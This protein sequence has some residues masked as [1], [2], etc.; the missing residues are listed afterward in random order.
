MKRVKHI[1]P[2]S[3]SR[4]SVRLNPSLNLLWII[5]IPILVF[6][7]YRSVLNFDLVNWDDKRYLKETPVIRGIT[8]DNIESMFTTKVLRS[9]NPLVLLS[10]AFDYEI[11]RLDPSWCHAV[12]LVFHMINAL[13]VFVCMKKMRFRVE[14]AGLISLLFALH[15]LA[16]EAVAWIAGRKDVLYGFFYLLAIISYLNFQ[17]TKAKF[18]YVLCLLLFICSLLSKVQ[19]ITFPFILI[20]LDYIINKEWRWKYFANK[21]PFIILSIVFGLIAISGS[22]MMAD[23]Y[24]MPVNFGDKIIYSAMAFGLYFQKLIFP[25]SQSAIYSFPVSGSSEYFNY[26]IRGIVTIALMTA[27]VI[28]SFKKAP[29]VSGGILFYVISIFIVLHVVAFNSAL[30]YERFIYLADIGL[31]ISLL[32]L[33]LIFPRVKN[34]TI[35]SSAVLL[36]IFMILTYNRVFIWKN[37]ETMWSDTILKNPGSFEA[38]NNRGMVFLIV[39][40]TKVRIKILNNAF[41]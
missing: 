23:K 31:F 24:S 30:I 26:L 41:G 14:V 7:V 19:A 3:T 17:K 16:V 29:A 20:V 21:I 15:P 2:S 32:N 27:G 5:I 35:K 9:Y 25:F 4:A 18:Q 12:N 10:F 11:A 34:Y 40:I 6:I 39:A 28:Y 33:D 8:L 1:P 37:S 22:T 36:V 38:Y 13:L